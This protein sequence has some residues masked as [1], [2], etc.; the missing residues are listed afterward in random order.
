MI[1]LGRTLLGAA[2]RYPDR[3][4]IVDG[5][6]RWTY[7]KWFE[8]VRHVAGGLVEVGLRPG[9]H[10]VTILKNRWQNASLH[11][12]CQLAGIVVT[13]INWRA[14]P[15]E[16]DFVLRDAEAKAVA[17]EMA[18]E[19]AVNDTVLGRKMPR[20]AVGGDGDLSFNDLVRCNPI[21]ITEKSRTQDISVMLYTSGTTG[22][23]KGV[24]R[25]HHAERASSM[26]HVVQNKYCQGERILG[27]MPL[28]HTM[29]VRS[30]LS[31]ALI[32]GCFICQSHFGAEETLMLVEHER[33]T[34]L[35]LVPTL[36]HDLLAHESFG[37]RDLSSVRKLGFAGAPMQEKLLRRVHEAFKPE[38]FVNH[39]GS[40]EIYTF[41]VETHASKNPGSVGKAGVNQRLR[42]IKIGSEDPEERVAAGETGQ[43]IADLASDE[44]F[45]GYW[46][47]PDADENS[48]RGGWYFTGDTGWFDGNGNLFLA[49][50]VDD[51]IIAGGENISPVEIENV[52]S[53][54]SEV[55][56][57]VVV[58]LA[59]ERW[60]QRVTAFIKARNMISPEELDMFCRSSELADF[61][62]P[63]DYV[64][65]DEIPKSPVGKVL[66]RLLVSGDYRM[67]ERVSMDAEDGKATFA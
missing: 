32:N 7:E 4:A 65:L 42:V 39:Y 48:L 23:G 28:Y 13:P 41:S 33:I 49:G 24:P 66:R 43:I 17:F 15:G 25:S 34:A 46:R 20:I 18:T 11:W 16:I 12:A 55:S 10:L 52:L 51:M 60:G 3:E 63:R 50:R 19:V 67:D 53:A 40:S 45:V 9:D 35:F 1:D 30:L 27:V 57:V 29:G 6:T 44:A 31:M 59:D 56:E 2:E 64:F 37:S 21:G 38:V 14:K 8:C 36:Y 5:P 47:R 58:G 22:R 62:R 54:H 61:K 26:A